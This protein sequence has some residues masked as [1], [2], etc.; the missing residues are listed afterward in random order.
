VLPNWPAGTVTILST[1][2]Q[3]PHAIPVSSAI[4]AGPNRVLIALA[5]GRESLA[6]LLADPRVA[7]AILSE[8]DVALTAH[9]NARVIQED[10]IDG[11]VAVEIEVQRVQN[12]GRDTFVIEAG[13][14]WRWNDPS[15]QARDAEVRAAL[16]RLAQR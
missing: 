9:G 8:A 14:R 2:G 13:V 5:A 15:A 3:E 11:V 7:L 6:R 12:H 10:L 16:E 4:R 1:S